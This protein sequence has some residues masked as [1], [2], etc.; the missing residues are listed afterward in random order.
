MAEEIRPDASWRPS[1]KRRTVVL[2]SLLAAWTTIIEARLVVLQVVQ[3]DELVRRTT[4]QQQS[5]I[6]L[7]PM[8]GDISDR[9]GKLLAYS[10][11]AD[12]IVADPSIVEDADKTVKLLCS[13]LRDCTAKDRQ[14]LTEKLS[15]DKRFQYVRRSR[16]V[17]PEQAQRVAA[18]HLEGVAL[19]ADTRRYYPRFE[20][21]A[22][23]IGF[24]GMDNRGLAGIESS[25]E[26]VLRG[27]DGSAIAQVDGKQERLQTRIERAPVTGASLELTV[28]LNLQYIVERELKAGVE[29]NHAQAGT[30]IV[31]DPYTGEV[32]AMA[33]YPTFNP[34]AVGTASPDQLRNGAITIV[35]EPGSTFKIVTASAALESGVVTPTEMIGTSPGFITFPGRK[36]IHDTH[37]YGTLSFEDVIVKSSNVGAIKVGLRTGT[38]RLTQYVTRFGFGQMLTPDLKGESAGIWNPANLNE[39]GLASVAM[40]YQISV[41]P[42]QMAAAAS[43]VANGGLLM[44][45]HLVRAVIRDGHRQP[46]TPKV[47]RRAISA[48]TAATLT[49]MMEGVV[50]RGTAT[51][52]KLTGYQT[53]GKTGTAHKA[54]AHGY[55][56][57]DYN[58]SFVGFVPSRTPA[59]TILVVIDTPRAGTYYGGTVAAPIF[60]KIAEAALQQRGVP[61]SINPVPPVIIRSQPGEVAQHASV[62]ARA[63]RVIHAGGPAVMPDLMGLSAREATRAMADAGLMPRLS[64]AG[65]VIR[66]SPEPGAPL[67]PGAVGAA[68]LGRAAIEPRTAGG[69][70]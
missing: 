32:L 35:Y 56:N 53:A 60:K 43:S 54:S 19:Q 48:T 3:H 59:F 22:H 15:G 24:V 49:A 69:T 38:A 26:T 20:L 67:Q 34:N 27:K 61:S 16:A 45:P 29:A 33:S 4:R 39:S 65:A 31:L 47:L 25:Y 6:I 37:N 21:G 8:R 68:E 18:L 52:A 63:P 46:V 66:Q 64:G 14:D 2:L 28:D 70:W 42:M 44:E 41:T 62:A 12:A 57:T 50:D 13:A 5:R 10:V 36:P 17:S 51:A 30:A 1:I 7:E 55:S 9:D 40:G 11:Y 58:A 23:A